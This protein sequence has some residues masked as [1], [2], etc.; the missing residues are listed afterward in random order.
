MHLTCEIIFSFEVSERLKEMLK[1]HFLFL[2]LFLLFLIFQTP[3]SDKYNI[4][5]NLELI[6][7][8]STTF[9]NNSIAL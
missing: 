2:F 8:L 4:S 1:S 9:F 6:S 5:I 7:K 3:E